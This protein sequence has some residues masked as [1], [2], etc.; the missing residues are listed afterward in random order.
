MTST[1]SSTTPNQCGVRVLNST[2]SP[3]SMTRPS[4][5]RIRGSATGNGHRFHYGSRYGHAAFRAEVAASAA[6]DPNPGPTARLT[7]EVPE[8]RY[9]QTGAVRHVSG[10]RR[11]R[12]V[13]CNKPFTHAL[14]A[15][16]TVTATGD[17]RFDVA[18]QLI[19]AAPTL[20]CGAMTIGFPAPPCQATQTAQGSAERGPRFDVSCG[21]REGGGAAASET[22]FEGS[23]EL[24]AGFGASERPHCTTGSRRALRR[25][26]RSPS[27][28][29]RLDH[30]DS[31]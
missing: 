25:P 18:M 19:D 15:E 13:V 22:K 10:K 1:G 20:K 9:A 23:L 17:G 30:V 5:P 3:G 26:S 21:A 27:P 28:G 6:V 11:G 8:Q 29:S 16:A 24:P 31:S 7:F 12:N 14:R 2:A 4:S